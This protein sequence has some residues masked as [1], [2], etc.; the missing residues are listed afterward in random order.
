[1]SVGLPLLYSNIHSER[2]LITFIDW[3]TLIVFVV[4]VGEIEL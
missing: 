2:K 3:T 1:M 4:P